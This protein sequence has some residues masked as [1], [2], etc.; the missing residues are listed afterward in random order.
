MRKRGGVLGQLAMSL[1]INSKGDTQ[2]T[3]RKEQESHVAKICEQ[4]NQLLSGSES[5]SW[6][7]GD[8]LVELSKTNVGGKPPTLKY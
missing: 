8:L 2:M 4:L 7:A 3:N 1:A 5:T 6:E